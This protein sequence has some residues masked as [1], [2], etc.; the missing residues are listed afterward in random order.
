M[1]ACDDGL[2]CCAQGDPGDLGVCLTSNACY[3]SMTACTDEGC[4][5]AVQNPYACNDTLICCGPGEAGA[6]GTCQ[7]LANC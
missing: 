7:M 4:D 2:M 1:G 5:C 3:V 6:I